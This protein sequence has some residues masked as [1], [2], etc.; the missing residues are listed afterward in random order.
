MTQISNFPS[1]DI[2][3]Y[4]SRLDLGTT[5]LCPVTGALNP[6]KVQSHMEATATGAECDAM[7][8]PGPVSGL[9][10]CRPQAEASGW[11]E[12]AT[13][14]LWARPLHPQ[15]PEILAFSDCSSLPECVQIDL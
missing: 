5:A 2:Q 12:R 7:Q 1:Q 13:D 11:R 14:G 3:F 9:V 4:A 15:S 8:G 6:D 10:A